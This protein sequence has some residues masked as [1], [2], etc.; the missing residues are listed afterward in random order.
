LLNLYEKTIQN[1]TDLLNSIAKNKKNSTK[2]DQEI[3]AD[4]QKTGFY[5]LCEL[6][7]NGPNL[8]EDELLQIKEKFSDLRDGLEIILAYKKYAMHF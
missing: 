4:I 2:S 5:A 7:E 8:S 1:D 6:V 3:A